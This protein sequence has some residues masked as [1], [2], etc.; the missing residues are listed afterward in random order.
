MVMKKLGYQQSNVNHTIFIRRKE[1]KI[2]IL[3]VYVDDIVLTDNDPTEMKRIKTSLVIEFEMIDLGELH[4]FLGIEVARSKNRVVLSQK[5]VLDLLNDTRMLGCQPA[6][7]PIDPN[8]KLIGEIGDQVD[9]G[10]YQRLVGRLLYLAH[11]RPDIA[12]AVSVVSRYMHDPRV[13]H[14]ET[15]Y[16]ILRYLKSC[17]DKGVLFSKNGHTIIEVYTYAD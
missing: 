9:R 11:T 7:T 5:Y 3:V 13:L 15:V 6:S 12:Y 17:P 8:H 2:C 14:Q 16:Q 4:Y 10:Q 1:E